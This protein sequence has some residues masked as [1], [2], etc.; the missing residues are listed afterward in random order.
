[1]E[2]ILIFSTGIFAL[3]F[4]LASIPFIIHISHKFKW[5][6]RPGKRKIHKDLIPRIGGVGIFLAFL[7]CCHSHPW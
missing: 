1:M 2:L 5:Y 6:D 3:I 7:Y 4:S